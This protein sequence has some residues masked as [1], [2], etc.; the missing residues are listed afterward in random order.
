V[1][2]GIPVKLEIVDDVDPHVQPVALQA[3]VRVLI[4]READCDVRIDH[5]AVSRHHAAISAAEETATIEDLGSRHGTRVNGR[6]LT[7]QKI[8]EL[9]AGDVIHIGPRALRVRI[10]GSDVEGEIRV[11]G[12]AT[13]TAVSGRRIGVP[14]EVVND[15]RP[16]AAPIVLRPG[17]RLVIGRLSECDIFVEDP[18]VSRQHAAIV[19]GAT[20]DIT[21]EDLGSRH[22]TRVN[23]QFVRS[24]RPLELGEGDVIQLG[25]R[26][27]RIRAATTRVRAEAGAESADAVRTIAVG[28][29]GGAEHAL[30][31][32]I[33]VVRGIPSDGNTESAG[34]MLLE[35]LL[36]VTKLERALLVRFDPMRADADII[37]GAG[38]EGRA[39]SRTVL[40]SAS[41]PLR[42]AHLSQSAVNIQAAASIAGTGV[43]EVLC[44]RVVVEGDEQLYLYLDSVGA[45]APVDGAMAE[46]V[47]AAARICGLVIESFA[48]RR[49]EA[50]RLDVERARLVQRRLLAHESGA[51]EGYS[52]HLDSLPGMLLAGDFAGIARRPDGSV[53]AWIGD[54]SGKGAAA[55]MLMATAQSWMYAAATR[56]EPLAI[57]VRAL[58]E[59][60]YGKSE[61]S[62]FAT[63]FVAVLEANGTVT[64]CDAGHG[65]AYLVGQSGASRI[66]AEGGVPVGA[67]PDAEYATSS[68]SLAPGAR[69]VMATDGVYEQRSS[70]GDAFGLDRIAT[71][72]DGSTGTS[73]DVVHIVDALRAHAGDSFDDDVT[74]LSIER[75]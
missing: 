8:A 19:V 47:G 54:V 28:T 72:L 49:L 7:P 5:P 13:M 36:S 39:V 2:A 52:W 65:I 15:S 51:I 16:Q 66:D 25:P 31:V 11:D 32:L 27:L 69:L 56:V 20:G 22:G 62:E 34:R 40:A 59:F 30:R 10:S 67:T 74:V 37:A 33:D 26:L 3:G 50:L 61:P 35:K 24:G 1:S 4:G 58:S 55:A 46:F 71:T 12:S 43:R 44:A 14:L 17:A 21:V 23:G 73:D 68:I 57:T 9:R 70:S 48:R 41:D 64:L 63:M 38:A 29:H 18:A 42:V 75:R 53:L 6:A 60:L 45:R